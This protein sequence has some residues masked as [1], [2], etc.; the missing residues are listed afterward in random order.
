MPYAAFMFEMT[1][2]TGTEFAVRNKQFEDYEA[3]AAY[4]RK[5]QP[6][7]IHFVGLMK[8]CVSDAFHSTPVYR[9]KH[10]VIDFD[11]SDMDVAKTAKG[12]V[13]A[14]MC[15][16]GKALCQL[17]WEGIVLPIARF[18]AHWLC[19]N[20]LGPI[21]A[22]YSGGRGVHIHAAC[23]AENA[24]IRLNCDSK[25][26]SRVLD[27]MMSDSLLL[28]PAPQNVS[29]DFVWTADTAERYMKQYPYLYVLA[30]T[31]TNPNVI[32]RVTS[33][34]SVAFGTAFLAAPLAML[35]RE[36]CVG[37]T[38]PV[39]VP[40]SP[41]KGTKNIATPFNLNDPPLLENI[42][43]S[44]RSVTEDSQYAEVFPLRTLSVVEI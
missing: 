40:Y 23:G 44:F 24:W 27:C 22:V 20:G 15:C 5:E 10:P 7:A 13:P 3:F 32:W 12:E 11:V 26:L 31:E 16:K 35:D 2:A 30:R 18:V 6:D 17:C 29:F 42:Q 36:A 37:A 39:R 33:A 34:D 21:V 1:S 4:L 19:S 14:R 9:C 25:L 43:R 41:H 8:H 38:H 28:V